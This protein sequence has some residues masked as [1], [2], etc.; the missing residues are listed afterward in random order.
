MQKPNIK[1]GTDGWRGIIADDFT[2]YGVQMVT[3]ALCDWIRA[4]P[5]LSNTLVVGYDRRA[6]SEVFADAVARVGAAN[7]FAVLLSD[8]ACASPTVSLHC[9]KQ[10]AMGIMITA[11]HNPPRFNGVKI[12]AQY[13]GA[14]TPAVIADIEARTHALLAADIEPRIADDA[15]VPVDL[16]TE[17][18]RVCAAFVDVEMLARARVDG[19]PI[20]PIIDPMHGSGAGY[21]PA[22]L[23]D[24]MNFVEVRSERNPFFGGVAPEPIAQNMQPLFDAVRTFQGTVGLCLDGDADRIGGCD[25]L[26]GFVSSHQ[27]FAVLLRH[28]H[29]NKHWTGSVVRTVSTTRMLDKLCALY[30][31]TLHETPIGFKHVTEYMLAEEVLIGGEESGGIGVSRHLPERDG[32]VMALLILEAVAFTGKRLEEL[33][34]EVFDLVGFHGYHR[35]D[36]T[37]P[38]KQMPRVLETVR[39]FDAA[40][41]A[42]AKLTEIVRMDGARLDFEDGSWL[43]LRPSGTEPVVRV[44]SEAGSVARAQELVAA[45]VALLEGAV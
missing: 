5:H 11:S 37:F 24:K 18:L 33:I 35:R 27:I 8:Q 39:T 15:P 41:F 34:Q 29:E 1:F 30:G 23:G 44:Y 25:S 3:Q 9:K 38:P 26:G 10:N 36:L 20:R 4:Q 45:G 16:T 7:G 12:K 13:G 31:I 21:L 28:L 22:V 43:L 42:G 17:Y 32:T 14:A 40:E 6:Q 19:N 2:V